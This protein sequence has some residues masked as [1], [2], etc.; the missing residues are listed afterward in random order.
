MRTSGTTSGVQSVLQ[1]IFQYNSPV[2]PREIIAKAWA[3]TKKERGIRAWGYVGS[4][5]E[6]MLHLKVLLYQIYFFWSF[7][8]VGN[9]VGLFEIEEILYEYLP[10]GVFFTIIIIFLV[11][12][13]IELFL[14]SLCLGAII[15]LSAKSYRKEEVK[16]GMILG[17]YNFFPLFVLK[18]ALVLSSIS[19]AITFSSIILRY[20]ENRSLIIFLLSALWFLWLFSMCLRFLLSFAEECVVIRKTSTFAAMGKSFKLVISHLGKIV[21]LIVL[22]F[23]IS[24]RILINALM[25]LL[26]PALIVGFAFLFS[27]FLSATLTVILTGIIALILIGLASYLFAYLEVFKQTA[28]TITF[29]ELNALKDLDVIET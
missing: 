22:L 3:I 8:I 19:M 26:L 29:L 9:T 10:V 21:F 11:M 20:G 2:T 18:E 25:A 15:G 5:F 16:G 24:L 27:L 1:T 4:F 7:F 12:L 13:V 17:L 28:W 6:T 23:V 14:P